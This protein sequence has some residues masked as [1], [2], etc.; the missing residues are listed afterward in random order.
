MIM[1]KTSMQELFHLY[2]GETRKHYKQKKK[3]SSVMSSLSGSQRSLASHQMPNH[4]FFV[5]SK[6]N[7]PRK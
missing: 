5:N 7:K 2:S 1:N 6:F 3:L 4:L